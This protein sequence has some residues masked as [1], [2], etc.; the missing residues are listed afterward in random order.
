MR[1]LVN[2]M[3]YYAAFDSDG[4]Y[5]DVDAA[6]LADSGWRAGTQVTAPPTPQL[7]GV[8]GVA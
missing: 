1:N 5:V 4:T 7:D 3:E 6:A 8:S 2:A